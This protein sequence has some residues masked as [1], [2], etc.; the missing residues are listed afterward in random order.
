M[1]S[2]NVPEIPGWKPI[3]VADF[4]DDRRSDILWQHADGSVALW[5]MNGLNF[6]AAAGLLGAGTGWSPV[7]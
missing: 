5:L 1:N 4:D 7:P 3:R 6:K 2:V